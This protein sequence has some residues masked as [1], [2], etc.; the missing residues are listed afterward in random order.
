MPSDA[1]LRKALFVSILLFLGISGI[2]IFI[3]PQKPAYALQH[4]VNTPIVGLE[5]AFTPYEVWNILGDPQTAQG[6]NIRAAFE[7]GVY[8]DFAYIFTYSLC[9]LLL[10]WLLLRRHG[11][12]WGWLLVA[13]ILVVA[14][15]AADVLENL[16]LFRILDTGT[17]ALVDLYI[18]QLI[19]FTRLKWLLL[20]VQGLPAAVLLRREMRRGPSF[21]LTAAFAFGALGVMKQFAPEIMTLFLAFFWV[22]LF[23]KLLPLKNQWWA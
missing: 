17:E 23:V 2:L 5:M 1:Q 7:K 3:N 8:V 11:V 20:G 22:Y 10:T 14:T 16:A 19:V 15:A 18:D 13:A 4:G 6:Q 12:A 9:Y 21:I